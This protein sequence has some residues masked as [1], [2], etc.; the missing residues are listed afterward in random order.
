MKRIVILISGRGSN[1]QAIVEAA[2]RERWD[3]KVVAVI[4]NRPDAEGLVW[5]QARGIET[6]VVDHT[7]HADRD[8]FDR[9]LA[10]AIKRHAADL[11]LMAGFMR[12]VGAAFVRQHEGRMLN[13]HPSLLPAYPGLHTHRKAIE[14]GCKVAGAT[15]HFVTPTL[16]HGPIVMQAAVHVM[17]SDTEASLAARVLTKEHVIYP[18]S[19][20]WWLE[21]RLHVQD[22]RVTHTEGEAQWLL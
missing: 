13:I 14:D 6:D 12:I 19:V 10:A 11:V 1:M 9:A 22:G 4:S 15:V 21:G 20:R 8:A 16:D 5:A 18:R 2:A 3:A 7:L 17:A